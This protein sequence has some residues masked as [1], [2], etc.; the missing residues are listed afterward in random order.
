MGG[1]AAADG[2]GVKRMRLR[3]PTAVVLAAGVVAAGVL[4]AGG[5]TP[6]PEITARGVDGV[7]LAARYTALRRQGLVGKIRHGCELGGARTRSA[8]VAAPLSGSVDFSLKTPRRVRDILIRG[9][10]T[11]RGVGIGSSLAQVQAAF[12]SAEVN[13]STEQVFRLTLVKVPKSD[14]GRFE[15]A[16]DVQSGQVTMIGIPFIAFCE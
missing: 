14:G 3:L 16:V 5:Q 6:A 4:P 1:Q 10:A 12:P 11:A 13:H 7:S 9:G 15:F 2:G 8:P